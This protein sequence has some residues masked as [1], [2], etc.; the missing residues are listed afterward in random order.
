MPPYLL[1][2]FCG[3]LLSIVAGWLLRGDGENS[4]KIRGLKLTGVAAVCVGFVLLFGDDFE[5]NA[6]FEPNPETWLPV[7]LAMGAPIAVTI[8]GQRYEADRRIARSL[9][10]QR[11]SADDMVDI[12]SDNRS[13]AS[14]EIAALSRLGLSNVVSVGGATD[15]EQ[16][17]EWVRLREVSRVDTGETTMRF[18]VGCRVPI[19]DEYE[20]ETIR[21]QTDN[22]FR[23]LRRSPGSS[24]RTRADGCL[25]VVPDSDVDGASGN[26]PQ[27]VC[28]LSLPSGYFDVCVDGQRRILVGVL[29]ANHTVAEPW[30]RYAFGL[31]GVKTELVYD[32]LPTAP[33]TLDWSANDATRVNADDEQPP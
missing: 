22:T 3:L 20:L 11:G 13:W 7:D 30:A 33:M 18:P 15:S 23:I 19:S 21:Y 2:T 24:V 6:T 29:A 28:R 4:L 12:G 27:S 10:I 26:A 32:R 5:R 9:H 14:I 1:A 31:I 25:P 16:W 8:Q 17:S